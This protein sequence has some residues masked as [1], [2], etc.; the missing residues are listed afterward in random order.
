[1]QTWVPRSGLREV[2]VPAY[3]HRLWTGR[4]PGCQLRVK[5]NLQLKHPWREHR[6]K[7]GLLR[8]QTVSGQPEWVSSSN[9]DRETEAP[10]SVPGTAR[11]QGLLPA[12]ASGSPSHP[13]CTSLEAFTHMLLLSNSGNTCFKQQRVLNATSR[14]FST[15]QKTGILGRNKGCFPRAVSQCHWNRRPK[16]LKHPRM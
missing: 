1:M 4:Q 9:S 12:A 5:S 10:E 7:A 14:S 2:T 15:L 13:H 11:G 8:H 3:H 16:F 6:E